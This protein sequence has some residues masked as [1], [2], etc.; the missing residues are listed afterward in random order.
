MSKL[1]LFLLLLLLDTVPQA[2]AQTKPRLTLTIIP[3]DYSNNVSVG[4]VISFDHTGCFYVLLTN[5]SERPVNLFEEWN[6]WGYFGLSFDLTYTDGRKVR[7]VKAGRGW[8]KNFAS[9]VTIAPGGFFVFPVTFNTD[10]KIG[11]V[12]QNSPR[13]KK[14]NG[15]G[16]SCRMRA[17]YSI[18][19]SREATEHKAWTGT[20]TSPEATYTIWP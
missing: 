13:S 16:V 15:P 1:T 2:F 5:T 9:T 3:T 6:S 11:D 7:A 12:W 8:D 19:S 17:V 18:E 10:P 14:I 4:P 20:I